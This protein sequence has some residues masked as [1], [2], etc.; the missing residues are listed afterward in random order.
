M[1]LHPPEQN[2]SVPPRAFH[3]T[4]WPNIDLYGGNIADYN[5]RDLTKPSDIT[6]AFAGVVGSLSKTFRNG[7]HFGLRILF[8]DWALLWQ[9]EKPDLRFRKTVMGASGV[10]EALELPSWSWMAW[11]GSLDLTL[12]A[13]ALDY[14]ATARDV[15]NRFLERRASLRVTPI[16][17]WAFYNSETQQKTPLDASY[18]EYASITKDDSSTLP[19]GW[20]Q[21]ATGTFKHQSDHHTEFKYPIQVVP[22]GQPIVTPAA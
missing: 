6:H 14:L 5:D 11:K 3:D 2:F 10:G 18:R 1:Y 12:V 4:D 15:D 7:F 17:S 9:P 16:T 22:A 8:F 13:S 21:T 19:L 20:Y